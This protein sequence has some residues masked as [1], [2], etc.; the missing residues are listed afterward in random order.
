MH[1]GVLLPE[2]WGISFADACVVKSK[3]DATTPE[4]QSFSTHAQH[5]LPL[6]CLLCSRGTGTR[7]EEG[8]AGLALEALRHMRL[9][10]TRDGDS[11]AN[12]GDD[13][14]ALPDEPYSELPDIFAK[15]LRILDQ[16]SP[17]ART[18]SITQLSEQYPDIAGVVVLTDTE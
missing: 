4:D 13:I 9:R 5:S 18:D 17:N 6:H 8:S 3:L 16:N 12:A 1:N 14:S 10:G 11:V 7:D 15:A 2:S